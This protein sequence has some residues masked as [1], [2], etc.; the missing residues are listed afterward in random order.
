MNAKGHKINIEKGIVRRADIETDAEKILAIY[1]PYILRTTVT[2]EYD[3]ISPES[4]RL[5]MA[6]I[7]KQ[8][9]YLVYEEEGQVL[10][11]AYAAPFQVRAAFGWDCETSVY[12]ARSAIGKGAGSALY[13]KLFPL[14]KQ[15]GYYNVY[16]RI[17]LPNPQ[18]IKF[19]EKHGFYL[20]SIQKQTGYKMGKWLDLAQL[21]KRIGDFNQIPE[22]VRGISELGE[23]GG[24]L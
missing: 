22:P 4:F 7:M 2:F 24:F 11:Y 16:A 10:G 18:S 12:L 23:T 13:D 1:E 14:L 6:G 9:P 21:V 20:E 17:A 8:F 5:R 15:Q 3:K 19:H